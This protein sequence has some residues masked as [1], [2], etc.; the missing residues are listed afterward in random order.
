MKKLFRCLSVLPILALCAMVMPPPLMASP[1]SVYESETI[2]YD[3]NIT[4]EVA[5]TIASEH[6]VAVTGI[7]RCTGASLH[8]TDKGLPKTADMAAAPTREPGVS[9]SR[10]IVL[11]GG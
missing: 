7:V 8:L 10:K 11:I 1:L 4:N 9:H 5:G 6:P 2:S 3:L